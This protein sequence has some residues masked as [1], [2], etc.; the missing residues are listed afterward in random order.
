[1]PTEFELIYRWAQIMLGKASV[2]KHVTKYMDTLSDRAVPGLGR[3]FVNETESGS[4]PRCVL[5]LTKEP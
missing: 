2:E 3:F 5:V 4:I 1:M